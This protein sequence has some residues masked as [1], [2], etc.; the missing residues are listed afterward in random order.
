V[1]EIA[2]LAR[3]HPGQVVVLAAAHAGFTRLGGSSFADDVAALAPGTRVIAPEGTVHGLWR[4]HSQ[5]RPT[6][7]PGTGLREVRGVPGVA[8]S[9]PPAGPETGDVPGAWAEAA[10][11]ERALPA[12][13]RVR[14]V[15]G[16]GVV[17][18]RG[19][20]PRTLVPSL[21]PR[22]DGGRTVIIDSSVT[23]RTMARQVLE[24]LPEGWRDR[25]VD[26]RLPAPPA[27][28]TVSPA[29]IQRIARRL[30]DGIDGQLALVLPGE[31]AGRAEAE[32]GQPPDAASE[33]VGAVTGPA[34]REGSA[35]VRAGG[36]V[37][38]PGAGGAGS[39]P[40]RPIP[41]GQ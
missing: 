38:G 6:L 29:S 27:G 26:V 32:A 37:A 20:S 8:V 7:L 34:A 4:A 41:R 35:G 18:Y 23:G 5:G 39:G 21:E 36:S 11:I 12:D 14:P 31:E 10:A 28:R 25:P 22:A 19:T 33:G 17:V 16:G 2:G 24:N 13:I 3:A 15:D 40:R 1:A 30:F 9:T